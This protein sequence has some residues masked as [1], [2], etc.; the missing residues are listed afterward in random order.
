MKNKE[1]NV[2]Y[3]TIVPLVVNSSLLQILKG[4]KLSLILKGLTNTVNTVQPFI[5]L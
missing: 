2:L 1:N 4:I 5:L 3:E